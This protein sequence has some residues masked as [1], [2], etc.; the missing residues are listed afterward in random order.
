MRAVRSLA[1]IEKS[2][3]AMMNCLALFRSHL[4]EVLGL[5]LCLVCLAQGFAA[6]PKANN[7]DLTVTNARATSGM[8]SGDSDKN[9]RIVQYLLVSQPAKGTVVLLNAA[10]GSYRFTPTPNTVPTGKDEFTFHVRDSNNRTSNKVGTISLNYANTVTFNWRPPRY[11]TY[12]RVHTFTAT[13][14]VG[15]I[16]LSGTYNYNPPLGTVFQAGVHNL[17]VTFVPDDN[18]FKEIK[19]KHTINVLKARLTITA[20]ATKIYG[21]PLPVFQA[22]YSG[23]VNGDT[24]ATALTGS[25]RFETS[26]TQSSPVGSYPLRVRGNKVSSANYWFNMVLG[27]IDIT[28]APAQV[29]LSQLNHT[30]DGTEKIARATTSPA[31]LAVAFSAD[32]SPVINAGN[33]Q[34]TATITNPNY[35]GSATATLNITPAAAQINIS[36]LLHTFNYQPHAAM[37]S[38]Q[39]LGLSTLVTY[40]G[41]SDIPRAIGSYAVAAMISD[42]NYVATA[43]ATLVIVAPSRAV[44]D[45]ATTSMNQSVSV[46]VLANDTSAHAPLTLFSF[47]PATHGTV[48]LGGDGQSLLYTP[49]AGFI[50]SDSFA[51]TLRDNAGNTDLGLV[52]VRVTAPENLALFWNFDEKDG[53]IV[54][55]QTGRRDGTI[56]GTV[57]RVPGKKGNSVLLNGNQ[58]IIARA[59]SAWQTAQFSFSCWMKPSAALASMRQFTSFFNTLDW[60]NNAGLYFGTLAQDNQLH[61]MVMNGASRNERKI[62]SYSETAIG[63]WVHVAAVYD[64]DVL[65]LYRN[66][67]SVASLTV[68]A[69]SIN[70][71]PTWPLLVGQGYNGLLDDVRLYAGALAPQDV[72]TLAGTTPRNSAPIITM[73]APQNMVQQQITSVSATVSDDGLPSAAL[74][75]RWSL[76]NGPAAVQFS[77]VNAVSSQ[78]FFPQPG[79][80]T[81][82]FGA[83]DGELTSFA[84]TYVVVDA[85]DDSERG[86]LAHWKMD[87]VTGFIAKDSSGNNYDATLYGNPSWTNGTIQGAVAFDGT[88]I[89]VADSAS[90]LRLDQF[91]ISAW[92]NNTTTVGEMTGAY[93]ALVSKMD[94]ATN[95]GFYFGVIE[96]HSNTFG[97]RIMTG[98]STFARQEIQAPLTERGKW[99]H[100]AGVCDGVTLRLYVDGNLRQVTLTGPLRMNHGNTPFILGQSMEGKI[101]DVRIYERSLTPSEVLAIA[102]HGLSGNG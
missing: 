53:S 92:I 50:G 88:Q 31:G 94:W 51:Y 60:A 90:G 76:L 100:V 63:E 3:E 10:T 71:S 95:S 93:P 87:D 61:F 99:T 102:V 44:D 29:L 17:E 74:T 89:G 24:A 32:R 33:Y 48:S 54:R 34:I 15:T 73:S 27:K 62:V 11:V 91:T 9:S 38:T 26:A 2:E 67:V 36:Q 40:N 37:I 77:A 18:N 56:S 101:D 19:Q 4:R 55:D 5:A 96:P 28:P 14:K 30:Y 81:L 97:L 41:G 70:H 66:G 16:P 57:V 64:G 21:Q 20:N 13:A 52:Y 6:D 43:N 68:G 25:F 84:D 47:E 79:G 75:Y 69:L 59:S 83:S 78:V 1:S 72:Q 80:Y 85:T 65:H 42:P 58:N 35:Q 49:S 45:D 22:T 39:P 82:R 12:G 86:L 8:L 46:S 23:F 7:G 98:N